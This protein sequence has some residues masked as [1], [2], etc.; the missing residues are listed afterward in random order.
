MAKGI[1]NKNEMECVFFLE[2][3]IENP[4]GVFVD[5]KFEDI[6][7]FYIREAEREIPNLTNPFARDYLEGVI[8]KYNI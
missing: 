4:C 5:G 3:H 6:R 1:I 2:R 7:K 8:R